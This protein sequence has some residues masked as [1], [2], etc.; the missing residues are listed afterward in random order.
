M[1]YQTGIAHFLASPIDF[2]LDRSEILLKAMLWL[3]SGIG[4]PVLPPGQLY[5]KGGRFTNGDR[6][7]VEML[8]NGW[9]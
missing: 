1:F 9:G 5:D 3:Y 8:A 7:W 4:L 2:A 6:V